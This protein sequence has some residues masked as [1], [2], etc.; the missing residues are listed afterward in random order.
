M[1][2]KFVPQ[3]AGFYWAKERGVD[4]FNLLVKVEGDSPFLHCAW[5]I[6]RNSLGNPLGQVKQWEIG[7]WHPD[8]ILAPDERAA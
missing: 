4:W 1:S 2:G 5:I 6:K 8:R 3:E 7:E